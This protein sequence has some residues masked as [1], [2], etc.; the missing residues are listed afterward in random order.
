MLIFSTTLISLLFVVVLWIFFKHKILLWEFLIL[1]GISVIVGIC[2]KLLGDYVRTVDTEYWSGRIVKAEYYEEWNEYIS[3]TCT[4]SCCCDSKGENCGTETYDCSYVEYHPEYWEITDNNGI[5]MRISKQVY[6]KLVTKFG[7]NSFVELNRDYHTI[8]GDKYITIWPETDE[9]L[10]CMVTEH[11]Y[12]NKVQASDNVLNFPEVKEKDIKKYGLYDYPIIHDYYRQKNLLGKITNA[13]FYNRKLEILNANLG[14]LKQ[15][16]AFVLLFRN[17]NRNAGLKQQAYWK[18]GNKNEFVVCIGLNNND[19]VQ[20]CYPFS[21][22][23]VQI[24]KINVRTYVEEMK[25]KIDLNKIITYLNN[26]L[27]N[28]FVRK[29]FA[30]F[31]YLTIQPTFGQILWTAIITFVLNFLV[32]LWIINNEF[33]NEEKP[34][35]YYGFRYMNRYKW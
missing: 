30:K 11:N 34:K 22:T 8:D 15:V 21:W 31:N 25:G 2:S 3:Q 4:R 1:F 29:P 5:T 27:K 13:E 12:E 33:N 17:Q 28:N 23:D 35:K 7:N 26:E 9:T 6:E 19:E 10:E 20:W 14:Q 32:S 24:T 16:K 18:G